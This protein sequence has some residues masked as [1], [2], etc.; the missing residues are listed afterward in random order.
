MDNLNITIESMVNP[1][2]AVYNKIEE[3]GGKKPAEKNMKNLG[4][5]IR[6]IPDTP[7]TPTLGT[8]GTLYTTDYPEG[9]L[10]NTETEYQALNI[11]YGQKIV[12]NVGE[13]EPS[14][15]TGFTFNPD[16]GTTFVPDQFLCY[17]SNL[18]SPMDIPN[19]V[20]NI[21][22]NFLSFCFKFNSPITLPSTLTTIGDRF[23]YSC[24]A[25]N[26]PLTLPSGLLNIRSQFMY[27]CNAFNQPLTIPSTVILIDKMFMFATA[28][29]TEPLT[30]ECSTDSILEDELEYF[31]SNNIEGLPDT[32]IGHRLAGTYASNWKAF[33]PDRTSAPYRKLI[34]G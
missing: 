21:G 4:A 32:T 2:T 5:A 8:Y 23:L 14:T 13:I 17:C 20:T 31:L 15:V 3:K 22:G 16:S 26:Q 9:I 10:I 6:S 24:N 30:V 25:F 27:D 33:L 18:N 29:F 19:G 11:W 34:L 28:Q 1:L 7:P 12:T